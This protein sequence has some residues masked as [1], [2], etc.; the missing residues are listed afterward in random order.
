LDAHNPGYAL[1]VL[2]IVAPAREGGLE[3][4]VTA[5]SVGQRKK[6]VHVAAILT[7]ADAEGH[8]FTTRLEALGVPATRVVVGARS[9][10]KEYRQLAALI[11]R[12]NPELV[13]THGYHADVI[14]GTLARARRIPTVSTAHGFTGGGRR[15]RIYERIQCLALRRA[16]A[17][18]AVSEPLAKLLARAGISRETIH[19]VPNAFAPPLNVV[20]R[21]AARDR[22]GI[23][24][25]ALVAGWVGRLSREKG[26]DVMLEALVEA[27]AP[28][29]LSIIG[30]GPERHVLERQ[31]ANLGIADRIT[32][33]GRVENA[34]SLL[35]AFDAFVLSSRTEGTPM[36]LFEAMAASVPIVAT[37]VGGVP[38]VV[39]SS[40]AILVPSEQP[41]MIARALADVVSEPSKAGHRSQLARE[42]LVQSYG[43]AK[44]L[45]AIS[46]VYEAARKHA[47]R[48][49]GRR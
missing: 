44:W 13:H 35:T 9:Y 23:A 14:A 18:I 30:D 38:D 7:P 43:T 45:D 25:G 21:L 36:T 27:D 16:N 3:H 6:G 49:H 29:Q 1:R 11:T 28:W 47:E 17:V 46:S 12:L 31:A 41:R 24:P 20:T 2:H 42:R 4:V 34:G 8:P 10:V 26:A 40:H 22:L 33:H 32:W 15:D 5:M 39:S 37:R 48:R 19:C